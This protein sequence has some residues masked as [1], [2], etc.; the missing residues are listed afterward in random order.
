MPTPRPVAFVSRQRLVG[1]TNGSSIYL[2]NLAAAVRRAG[3]E[4]ILIQPSPS[5]FGRIPIL[6]LSPDMDVFGSHQVRGA[7]RL[8]R[9]LIALRPSIWFAAVRG[10]LV[11]A[12]QRAGLAGAWL[13]DQKAPYSIA[14]PWTAADDAFATRHVPDGAIGV[15]DY[16]FQ[17]RAFRLPGVRV[18][19][20]AIV[21]HDLFHRRAELVASTGA[22][23]SVVTVSRADEVEMLAMADLVIAI[24]RDE[25]DFV[26]EALPEVQ[27]MTVPMAFAVGQDA[28]PGVGGEILFVGSNTEPNIAG[29]KW[30]CDNCWPRIHAAL[31][32]AVLTIVGTVSA[33]MGGYPLPQGARYAGTV[34]D[35]EPLYTRA[36][37]V[38][39]PLTFGSGLKIKLVE[40]MAKGKAIV[41]TSVTLQGVEE[42]AEAAIL[43]ADDP[44]DF[45]RGVVTLAQNEGRRRELGEKALA[46]AQAHFSA[47]AAQGRFVAWLRTRAED[48]GAP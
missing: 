48:L 26:A 5:I 34:P 42:F 46:V 15:A 37:V 31:P 9:Y 40:A 17:A 28:Q 41:A 14:V 45:V 12:A 18:S 3:L 11:R 7:A 25:A 38:I 35:L 10:V 39:S 36:G 22:R 47:D 32:E 1:R 29:L 33:G 8:G 23:D 6:R 16:I 24:Q 19:A 20:S 30:F 27:V 13:Q 2:L 44:D 43:K 4:P 21:M